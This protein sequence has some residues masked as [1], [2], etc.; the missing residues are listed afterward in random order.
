M[1]AA[2]QNDFISGKKSSMSWADQE[3]QAMRILIDNNIKVEGLSQ[4]IFDLYAPVRL[5]AEHREAYIDLMCRKIEFRYNNA[6]HPSDSEKIT[7]SIDSGNTNDDSSEFVIVIYGTW[8]HPSDKRL[9][10]VSNIVKSMFGPKKDFVRLY[11]WDNTPTSNYRDNSFHT[12][13][14]QLYSFDVALQGCETTMATFKEI[15]QHMRR[16]FD[17]VGR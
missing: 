3:S 12:Y 14:S 2:Q 9:S 17:R 11:S 16:G 13:S 8:N 15:E 7:V 4:E 1:S 6:L 10:T 5:D